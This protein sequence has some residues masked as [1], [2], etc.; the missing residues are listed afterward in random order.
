MDYNSLIDD[1]I[2]ELYIKIGKEKKINVNEKKKAVLIGNSS[3]EDKRIFENIYEIVPFISVDNLTDISCIVICSMSVGMLGSLAVGC[4]NC[5]EDRLILRALLE[6]KD[7]YVIESGLEYRQ[8][9]QSAYKTLYTLYSDYEKKVLQYGIKLIG[10]ISDIL[11]ETPLIK[12][13]SSNISI[14]VADEADF[15]YKN[16]LLE[17]DLIKLHRNGRYSVVLNN[18]CIV[19]PS[20]VD[21][22][23]MHNIGIKRI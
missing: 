10:H 7:V 6:E 4:C 12:N 1:V 3:N 15:T 14:S 23:K 8:Y 19:T 22:I 9:K 11:N 17:D 5:D 16:L 18:K 21:F 2:K 13:L 20:A